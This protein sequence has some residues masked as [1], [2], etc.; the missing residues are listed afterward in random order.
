[1][2]IIAAIFIPLAFMAGMYGMNNEFMP[3]LGWRWAYFAAWGVILLIALIM[4][5][6]SR[7]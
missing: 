5:I 4:V 1:M 7:R 3:G 6:Y 2:T